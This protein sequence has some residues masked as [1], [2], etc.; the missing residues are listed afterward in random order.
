MRYSDATL[1]PGA[2]FFRP[3]SCKQLATDM[4]TAAPPAPGSNSG[5]SAWLSISAVQPLEYFDSF[6]DRIV[7]E[8]VS[9]DS[10]HESQPTKDTVL[11]CSA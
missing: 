5:P 8:R 3:V 7:N 11:L 2:A 9:S 4:L 1:S 10:N 6:V